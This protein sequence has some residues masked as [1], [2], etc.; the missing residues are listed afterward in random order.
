MKFTARNRLGESYLAVGGGTKRETITKA[1]QL[2]LAATAV[3]RSRDG[4]QL[5]KYNS[6]FRNFCELIQIPKEVPGL[7]NPQYSRLST[8][9]IA[10][11]QY[12][13]EKPGYLS[14]TSGEII[15]VLRHEPFAGD[16]TDTYPSYL[17]DMI[18]EGRHGW[19]PESK[20][21]ELD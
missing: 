11:E 6:D 3:V 9:V 13:A 21:T 8:E 17:Y 15:L 5:C 1:G 10:V 16:R 14:F 20:V 19:F 7:T 18:E 12:D 2:A 4:A